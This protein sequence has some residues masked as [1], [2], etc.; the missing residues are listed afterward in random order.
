MTCLTRRRFL[1]IS[2]SAAAFP[3]FAGSRPSAHWRG[4]ALGAPASMRLEGLSQAEADPL[5]AEVERELL[6]LENIFSL[7]RPNS[8]ISRL[9]DAGRLDNPSV[10]LLEVLSL[11]ASLHHASNGL[12]DPTIQPLWL[13]RAK[14]HSTEA[15]VG[16]SNL[17]FD[18]DRITFKKPGMALTLN[19]IAQG[20]ITD[21]IHGLLQARGLCN[22]LI[23]MGE[24]VA[25]GRRGDLTPWRV[26]IADP[27]GSLRQRVQLSDRAL[28]TSATSGTVLDE[29]AA[30]GHILRPDG[31]RVAD[32]L[33]SVSAPRAVIA[34]GLSTALCLCDQGERDALLRNFPEAKLEAAIT[35]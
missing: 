8:E 9:N 4:V 35:L 11:S 13:A 20:L 3:A 34:D 1:S 17:R 30:Q 28:A 29:A 16:W 26:G 12:F 22:L 33:V 18:A 31:R 7:Y 5:F 32:Q 21:R 25:G 19:G 10:E 6:R 2:A 23:D 15:P 14:G 24:I 27:E